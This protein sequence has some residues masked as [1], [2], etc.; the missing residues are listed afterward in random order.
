MGK[1]EKL[2]EPQQPGRRGPSRANLTAKV[3]TEICFLPVAVVS[4]LVASLQGMK[5]QK[6]SLAS[7]SFAREGSFYTDKSTFTEEEVPAGNGALLYP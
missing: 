6:G 4:C 2:W 7:S 5:K 1:A 3:F